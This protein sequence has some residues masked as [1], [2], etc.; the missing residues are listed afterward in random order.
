MRKFVLSSILILSLTLSGCS[1]IVGY[2]S[3][4]ELLRAPQSSEVMHGIQSALNTYKNETVQLKY[5]RGFKEQ[6][7]MLLADIDGDGANEAVILYVSDQDG[8][9]VQL[10]VLES[11]EDGWIVVQDIEGLSTEVM[12][13]ELVQLNSGTT[14]IIVGY[15]NAT[16]VDKFLC[17]YSYKNGAVSHILEMAYNNYLIG[18]L[19]ES[20]NNDLLVVSNGEEEGALSAQ[21]LTLKSD[22]SGMELIQ[23]ISLDN[24]FV[25]CDELYFVKSVTTNG[26]IIEGTFA[27][28][29]TA[30]EVFKYIS[31]SNSFVNWPQSETDV[32]LTTL[33]Y[34][35]DLSVSIVDDTDILRLPTNVTKI[36]A[37]NDPNRFYYVTWQDYLGSDSSAAIFDDFNFYAGYAGAINQQRDN[38]QAESENSEAGNENAE[39]EPKTNSA[40]NEEEAVHPLD[41][42]AN[43]LPTVPSQSEP[44]FGIYDA[45]LNYFVR[46]PHNFAGGISVEQSILGDEW[47]VHSTLSGE[48]LLKVT[49][50]PHE[51]SE[52]GQIF[53]G[54]ADNKFIYMEISDELSPIDKDTISLGATMLNNVA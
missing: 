39:N 6:S 10:A 4:E 26:L 20:G 16:L 37:F 27:S 14:Q 24:R 21:W 17:V 29:W 40:T 3:V 7:P 46:L 30:N 52:A 43:I 44:Y 42:T 51:V 33:R 5:P 32:P 25:T 18:D 48:I 12:D 47:H 36:A 50:L 35:E 28:G 38:E 13:L 31:D 9:S 45:H 19:N 11:T 23:T 53:I 49:I 2:S 41:G 8:Q 22:E 15:A 34:L 54:S 1:T